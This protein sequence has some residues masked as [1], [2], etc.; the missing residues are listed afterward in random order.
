MRTIDGCL[1]GSVAAPVVWE[2]DLSSRLAVK[3]P[4]EVE[5]LRA[6]LFVMAEAMTYKELSRCCVM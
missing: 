1:V 6:F 5:A 4:R 3:T 2:W